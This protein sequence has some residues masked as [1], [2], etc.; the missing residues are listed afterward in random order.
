MIRLSTDKKQSKDQNHIHY[1][2]SPNL[3]KLYQ[4]TLPIYTKM[5]EKIDILLFK[6]YNKEF[7]FYS[8]RYFIE[9]YDLS[10]I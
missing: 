4:L 5:H 3:K 7:H 1:F 9:D 8:I 6:N 2:T 10:W